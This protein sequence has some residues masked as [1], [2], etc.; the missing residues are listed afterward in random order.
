M[1]GEPLTHPRELVIL[2]LERRTR[3]FLASGKTIQKIPTGYSGNSS[4]G[5]CLRRMQKERAKLA[6]ALREHADAGLTIISA[7][8]A[9]KLKVDRVQM[10]AM[11]NGIKFRKVASDSTPSI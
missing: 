6:P 2:E 4:D 11:E 3:E 10:I 1:V 8:N 7:A 5:P 9:M